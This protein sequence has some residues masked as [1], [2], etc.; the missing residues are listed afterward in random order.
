M[1][2]LIIDFS[3]IKGVSDQEL[4]AM[5][6][7][8]LKKVGVHW[9]QK[10]LDKHFTPAG[11][12]EYNY[13]ERSKKYEDKKSRRKGHRDPLKW[14]GT[15]Q[16]ESKARQITTTVSGSTGTVKIPLGRVFNL[17]G[18]PK[19]KGKAI[20]RMRDEVTRVSIK[21][22]IELSKVFRDTLDELLQNRL[23]RG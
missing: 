19:T 1:P 2:F 22:N 5:I 7:E 4:L 15:G 8:S 9:Q 10:I 21:D 6:H 20:V 16:K 3:D 13:T 18:N 11:A 17:P 12:S 23:T 14:S